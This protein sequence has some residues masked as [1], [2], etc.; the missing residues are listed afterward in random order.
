MAGR[1]KYTQADKA[2][3]YVVLTANGSNVKRT[4]RETGYPENTVRRWREEFKTNPP[5]TDL[6]VQTADNLLKEMDEVRRLALTEMRRKITSGE[7]K[8]QELN[9]VFGTLTDKALAIQGL[10]TSRT[11]HVFQLPTPE[12]LGELLGGAVQT[13]IR[14]AG[15]RQE[16]I[17]DADV[18]EVRRALPR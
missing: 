4:A 1:A 13:A 12:E 18:V 7:A 10:A 9:A 11:E 6:V 5:N 16:E 8:L 2:R 15:E 14:R 3:V 17:I